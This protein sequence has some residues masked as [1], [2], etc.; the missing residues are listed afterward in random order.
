MVRYNQS[1]AQMNLTIGK[2]GKYRASFEII[3]KIILK[4]R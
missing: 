2:Y 4:L 3:I 1:S